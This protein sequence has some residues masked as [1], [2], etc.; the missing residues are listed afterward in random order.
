MIEHPKA[1]G[2]LI[3]LAVAS[4][5]RNVPDVAGLSLVPAMGGTLHSYAPGSNLPVQWREGRFN[6]YS[7]TGDGY[8]P[9]AYEISVRLDT[10]G[11]GGSVRLHQ[12][13]EGDSVWTLP[14]RDDFTPVWSARK[15]LLIAAGIG[16]TPILSHA[17]SHQFW[18]RPYEVHYV[19]RSA[20]HL[21]D[22]L[23]LADA[24]PT[25]YFSREQFAGALPELLRR[26][27]MG[28]HLYVCGPEGMI[29]SVLGA[30]RDAY[31]P[32]ARLHHEAFALPALNAGPPF[33]IN[34]RRSAVTVDVPAG[35]TALEALEGAGVPARNLCRRGFC[36]E[37][38]TKVL[39]GKPL[40]RDEVLD[41]DE[42]KSGDQML[43]CV[44]RAQGHV[45]LDL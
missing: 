36:G 13:A 18:K 31:W 34:A 9:D 32:S 10:S 38:A 26:Q 39:D 7:L 20:V 2:R 22:F 27:P 12:L 21:D 4:V 6:S 37:C 24:D 8:Q 5:V 44:S 29:D 23:G 19:T 15:H 14:P 17:R 40:H 28:T 16:V 3:E 11:S 35:V 41:A 25:V 1:D 43:V 33:T 30:A 42:R 45:S